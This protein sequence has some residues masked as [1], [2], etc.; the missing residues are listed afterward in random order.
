[1]LFQSKTRIVRRQMLWNKK[2]KKKHQ[3]NR[4][5]LPIKT[6]KK[7]KTQPE[8]NHGFYWVANPDCRPMYLEMNTKW[9]VLLMR[10]LF[11]DRMATYPVGPTVSSCLLPVCLSRRVPVVCVYS[12]FRIGVLSTNQS[13]SLQALHGPDF[14]SRPAGPN[15]VTFLTWPWY[16]RRTRLNV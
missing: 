12:W 3:I 9:I 8:K 15:F 13:I 7:Q 4:K 10:S 16:V 14:I 6:P 1:M 5:F 2:F 11:F